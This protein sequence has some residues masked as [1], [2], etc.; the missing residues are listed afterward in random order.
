MK[1]MVIIVIM[2]M[3]VSVNA[4]ADPT[5]EQILQK[6]ADNYTKINDMTADMVNTITIHINGKPEKVNGPYIRKSYQKS[7]DK[8]KIEDSINNS[9]YI[10]NGNDVYFEDPKSG[11]QSIR[12]DQDG[13][14]D[15][16]QINIFYETAKA[17]EK[18]IFKILNHEVKNGKNI[19]KVEM[20]SKNENKVYKKMVFEI[21]YEDGLLLK[22]DF[23]NAA[24]FLLV[25]NE[26]VEYTTIDGIIVAVQV[27]ETKYFIDGY[28]EN[29][30]SYNNIKLNTG[31]SDSLFSP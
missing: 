20:A 14:F 12:L 9:S 25:T 22:D 11:L 10:I 30:I 2:M 23:Y 7:P 13:I 21:N 3:L 29:I 5:P 27:K 19:Y 8:S 17:I 24:D 6:V 18:N 4:Y 28:T 31:L 26:Q 1:R 15:S 16:S